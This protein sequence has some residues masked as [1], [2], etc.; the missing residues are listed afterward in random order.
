MQPPSRRQSSPIRHR[1]YAENPPTASIVYS[2]L[3]GL[4]SLTPLLPATSST[5][6]FS[7]SPPP[8]PPVAPASWPPV[9]PL[10]MASTESTMT[11][12]MP[13]LTCRYK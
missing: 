1:F 13:S 4:S 6:S 10:R 2:L 3:P 8:L 12:S 9:R 11:A 7:A 5:F